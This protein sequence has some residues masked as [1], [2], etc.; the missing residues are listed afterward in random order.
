VTIFF[1]LD[2][3]ADRRS[4]NVNELPIEV[5]VVDFQPEQFAGSDPCRGQNAEHG[6]KRFGRQVDD[7][8]YLFRREKSGF[9]FHAFV[10]QREVAHFYRRGEV[11]L[12]SKRQTAT[13]RGRSSDC[14]AEICLHLCHTVHFTFSTSG[15]GQLWSK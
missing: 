13:V 12:L 2:A 8:A 15:S 14:Y 3:P 5:E 9:D 10:R 11:P 7:F 6:A 4:A 1:A